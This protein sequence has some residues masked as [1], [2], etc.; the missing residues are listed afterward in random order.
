[1][2][3]L[4]L[5]AWIVRDSGFE[6]HSGLQVKKTVSSSLTRKDSILWGTS[7]TERYHAQPQTA[8]APISNP[9][10]GG[11][12]HLIH[13]T[14]LGKLPWPSLANMCTNVA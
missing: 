3:W 12:C 13:I 9:V 2:Q 8:R 7:V 11:L 5:C 14:I 4:K 10:S 1:M 6:P